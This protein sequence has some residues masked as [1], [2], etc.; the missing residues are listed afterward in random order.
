M[1]HQLK[2]IHPY[3]KRVEIGEKNFEL[4]KDDRD[5]QAGDT[6]DLL[7]YDPKTD[8]YPGGVIQIKITYV[9]KEFHGIQ[10]GYCV[11]G[12]IKT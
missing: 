7:E 12:F 4:R 10:P 3:F 8:E 11:F 6:V 5:F 2:T 1:H 9:L